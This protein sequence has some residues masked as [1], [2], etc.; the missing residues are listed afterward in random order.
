MKAA[1]LFIAFAL[2]IFHLTEPTTGASASRIKRGTIWVWEG[3]NCIRSLGRGG[4]VAG[5]K[6]GRVTNV[7]PLNHINIPETAEL[8]PHPLLTDAPIGVN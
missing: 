8:E 4:G 6:K 1:L 7:V 2:M 5:P 3:T